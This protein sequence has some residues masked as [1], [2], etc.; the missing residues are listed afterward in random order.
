[1]PPRMPSTSPPP[2]AARRAGLYREVEVRLPVDGEATRVNILKALQ[3]LD[4][5][6]TSRDVG[7][8]FLAGHGVTDAAVQRPPPLPG[9]PN[10][11]AKLLFPLS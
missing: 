11:A 3:W 4:G 7:L 8:L 1:M 10:S 2:C 5:E 9:T 6:V